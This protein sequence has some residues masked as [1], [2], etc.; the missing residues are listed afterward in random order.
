MKST[1]PLKP[2]IATSCWNFD[3]NIAPSNE[4]LLVCTKSGELYVTKDLKHDDII[5]WA[6]INPPVDKYGKV[7]QE[8]VNLLHDAMQSDQKLPESRLPKQEF[9]S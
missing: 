4:K 5:A 7:A 2:I 8:V 9:D 3:T 1:E 6:E